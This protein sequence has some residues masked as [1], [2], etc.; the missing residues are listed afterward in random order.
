VGGSAEDFTNSFRYLGVALLV[1]VF[2]VYM[3]MAS[4]FESLRQP[5]IILFSVPL[6][7]IGVVLAFIFTR[8]SMD[9]SAL[10]G[11]IMLSGIVVNNG[12][13]LIDAANQLRQKG[14]DRVAAIAQAARVRVRPVLL[15][16]MTTICSMIPLALELGEGSESWS[17]MATAVIGGLTTA[18]IL[19]LVVVPTMYTVFARKTVIPD[20]EE[21]P[22]G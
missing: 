16:S 18:T 22:A 13:V 10:I 21:I 9:V 8:R 14:F 12:I 15:T 11:V 1:A 5:F 17:G 6:A 2:L 20:S 7:A 3:V 19:T 4:Q